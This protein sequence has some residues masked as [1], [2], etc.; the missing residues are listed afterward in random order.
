MAVRYS[1]LAEAAKEI[2]QEAI[3]AH[4]WF[5]GGENQKGQIIPLE[6]TTLRRQIEET[7][8]EVRVFREIAH[9][10]LDALSTAG[11]GSDIDQ[12]FHEVFEVLIASTDEVDSTL[13]QAMEKQL[14]RFQFLQSLLKV[15]VVALGAF[16]GIVILRYQRRRGRYILELQEKE[17]DLRTTL[18][19][20]G[21]AVITTDIQGN[22]TRINPIAEK[23][24]G[25]MSEDA[26]GKSLDEVFNIVNALTG[27]KVDNPVSKVIDSGEVMELANHTMLVAK[28]GSKHQIADSGA[29]IKDVNGKIIG[30]VL[31]FR[32]VTEEYNTHKLLQE[33]EERFHSLFNANRDGYFIVMGGG[34]I[35]DANPRILEMLGYSLD[36]MKKQSFWE[37][38]PEKWRK[39]EY[40]VQG[41]LL[42]EQGYTDLYEKEYTRKDGTVFPIEVQAYTL[43]KGTDLESTRIGA[44]VRDISKR[45]N[46]EMALQDSEERFR[47][48]TENA[49]DMIYRMSL[50]EGRYEYISPAST[51][52][53]GHTPEEFLNSPLLIQKVIHPDWQEY[54]NE[55]WQALLAGK[56]PPFYEY[57]IIH[58]RT[59]EDRWL[60][61]RNVLIRDDE[62]QLIAIEGI[63]TD[64]TERK[65]AEEALQ[66]KT[67]ML[68][69][70]LQS[71]RGV[72][73][74][75]TDLD[76]RITYYNPLA[77]EF[78][79]YSAAE[80]IGKTVTE[81]HTKENVSPERFE[82][83]IEI[84]RRDGEYRYTVTQKTD[85]GERIL[86][87][88]VAGISNP[89]GEIVGYS[90]F[91]YD[92]TER[93]QAERTLKQKE[94]FLRESQRVTQIGSYRT[95]FTTGFW[96]SSET[97]DTIFGIDSEY[98]RSVEGWL[99][100]VHP[101]ER[102][103]MG[104][105]LSDHVLAKQKL[106]DYVYR[107]ERMNDKAIRW[108]HGLGECEFDE[109]GNILSMIGTIQDITDRKQ[110]EEEVARFSR[111]LE[112]SLNEIYIFDA[113]TLKFINVNNCARKNL[114]YSIEELR[115]LTPI[116][117]KP[118]ITAEIFEELV[119]PLNSGDKEVVQF[120]TVH[121][122]KDGTLYPVEVRLQLTSE[123]K[124]VFVAI[125]YDITE[126]KRA[127]TALGES[128]ARY[129]TLFESAGNA[130]F[131]MTK[132]VFVDCNQE[133][134]DMFGCKRDE[135][136]G[137]SPVE[138][139]PPVQPDGRESVEKAI[140]KIS[141]AL[142]GNPQLFEWKHK[143]LDGTLFDAEVSL[144]LIE[145]STGAFLQAI[146]RDITERKKAEE[147][148]RE[149]ESR[150]RSV[151]E[152]SND[153]IY[154]LFND[155][156][157]LINR[158]FT[159]LTGITKDDTE[160][161]DFNF[162]DTLTSES[163]TLVEKREQ[164]WER[165]EHP[166]SVYEFS[167]IHNNGDLHHVQASVAE[168]EY[169]DGKAILG[170]L[171][172]ITEHKSLEDQL[173]QSQKIESIGHLAGGIAHDFNNLLT[174]IIGNSELAMMNMEPSNPLFEDLRE[175]NQTATRASELTRQL[176]AFSRKQ[177]LDVKTVNLNKLIENFRKILRRTIREDVKIEMK[178]GKSIG[179]V[180]VDVSQI[181]QI[182]MN[183]L[184]NA[185]DAMP[186]GGLIIVE[187]SSVEIDREYAESHTS[188]KPG[189]YVLLSVSDTGE[190]MEKVTIQN[191]FDPFFTTKELG[192][193]TGLGLS[194]VY[195]IVKQHGGNIWVYS[196]PGEGTTFKLYLP[197]VQE[198]SEL[199]AG[200][201]H[202]SDQ[203]RG[204]GTILI[205]EDQEDVRLIAARILQACG[206][207][208][209]TASNGDEAMTMMREQDLSVDLLLTDVIMP[210]MNGQEL[211]TNLIENFPALK[212]VYMSG[213]T[214]DIISHHGVL[215]EG[216]DFIQKPLTVDMLAKKVK[217]V[218]E[219]K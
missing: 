99:D 159:E 83:A 146:V 123:E 30:L 184:V 13:H 115:E 212:V 151:I 157:D 176:L 14:Q 86:A 213:Y 81:M 109:Q 127:E 92:V 79:G 59:G 165:G 218:I 140:E 136:V 100:I 209:H 49:Q 198:N 135:I 205:V 102:E 43:E 63:V 28:D 62:G 155:R 7:L 172:D 161:P 32:N 179:V 42:L 207:T 148:L 22:I 35:L 219:R 189:K 192:K 126:R 137:H 199:S 10:R 215:E 69:N 178:Y 112:S 24:T 171:R 8:E 120:S 128:E 153:A 75:T 82:R 40:D 169:R 89:E 91:T 147:S 54:F 15:L 34:E 143:Q 180:R 61:Q 21:D 51:E 168:I 55:Q 103:E 119:T 67:M 39:W 73:I 71:A 170:I 186:T 47:R 104:A 78:F 214:Q 129:R 84:V 37:I 85:D 38:T 177:V 113:E 190:G 88:T 162:M 149:S 211:Y 138:F 65:L 173:R 60:H 197:I 11:I 160:D 36:E 124:P 114:G 68:D 45:K 206:Y 77:E 125:I 117:I 110:A 5:E 187:T 154:I 194:T 66:E 33:S 134:L 188:A 166:S 18:N 48:L 182:L 152:Q 183:L 12:R 144:N 150:F 202:D 3:I 52:M 64:V 210:N 19:S 193:G 133:T 57:K 111:V 122:R 216:I 164:M 131:L 95:D 142:A 80:V 98:N 130:I 195:G 106:F 27:E 208:V 87:S 174:P 167:L 72:S 163:R 121:Q 156:F 16:C 25:W 118:E 94:Y 46:A 101:D 185:Q 53:F 132:E 145:L 9:Q 29:P 217:E 44:F 20:I 201:S 41:T 6:D 26:K 50:P 141:A 204:T 23:L 76:F 17:E 90:L 4:L 93:E 2:K 139:S 203:H 74:A 58:G 158:R 96:E 175:I 191:I 56:M 31:V 70:I 1:P 108:V 105:Y 116:D 97:L 200:S 196:E 181:E 107:I